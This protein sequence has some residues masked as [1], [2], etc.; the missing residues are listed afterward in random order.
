MSLK[1]LLITHLTFFPHEIRQLLAIIFVAVFI[2]GVGWPAGFPCFTRLHA[3]SL[4]RCHSVRDLSHSWA[5]RVI[6]VQHV[7]VA[8]I[9]WWPFTEAR[10]SPD[11]IK[12]KIECFKKK[13]FQLVVL[14]EPCQVV[15]TMSGLEIWECLCK[16]NCADEF[17]HVGRMDSASI[18]C[19]TCGWF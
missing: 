8:M 7:E 17:Q 15:L 16:M 11:E 13:S 9:F 19:S 10:Y 14:C 3:N 2:G 18:D 4:I 6:W 1:K 5:R 12:I